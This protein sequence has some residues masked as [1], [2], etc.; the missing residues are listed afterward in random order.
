MKI[1]SITDSLIGMKNNCSFSHHHISR[2]A[3]YCIY[4]FFLPVVIMLIV[5]IGKNIYPFGNNCFLRTDLYHQ[6]LP[7]MC[8]F[9][10]RI[11][12]GESLNFSWNLGLGSNFSAIYAYYLASPVNW[13]CALCPTHD[14]IEF[15]TVLI[16]IK[17]GLCGA[18]CCYYFSKHF[19]VIND[20]MV[21]FSLFY[22]LS[23]FMAAYNWDI[24]WL[25]CIAL[26]PLIILGLEKLVSAGKWKYYCV[27][28][29]LCI[30]TNYYI[31]IMVCLF[32][33]L[34]FIILIL[35][36]PWKQKLRALIQFAF[37]SLLAAC[38]ASVV[39]I[40]GIMALTG[41]KFTGTT[42]P[43]SLEYYFTPDKVLARQCMDVCTELKNDHWPNIYCGVGVL[44][45]FPLYISCPKISL[46][47][48]I[49]VT[50]LL[51]FFILSFSL[52]TLNFIWH[53]LNYPDSLP[54]RQSFLYILVLLTACYEAF[55]HLYE[56]SKKHLLI[57]FVCSAAMVVLFYFRNGN[58]DHFN[59]NRAILSTAIFLGIYALSGMLFY[60]RKG[61]QD[62]VVSF[63]F[64]AALAEVG[65]NTYCTSVSTVSRS[66]YTDKWFRKEAV[67]AGIRKSD[68]DFFRIEEDDRVS[69]NDSVLSDFMSASIFSSTANGDMETFYKNIGLDSSKVY[70]SYDGDTPLTSMLLNVRYMMSESDSNLSNRFRT[71]VTHDNGI[72]IYKAAYDTSIGYMLPSDLETKW[73][74]ESGNSTS[75]QNSFAHALGIKDDL[76]T[77][78]T[79]DTVGNKAT[80][81][82]DQN[83]HL[84]MYVTGATSDICSTVNETL[85]TADGKTLTHTLKK[86]Q[87]SVL[88][89][90]GTLS[91]GDKL[92]LTASE[93]SL[94]SVSLNAYQLNDDAMAETLSIMG[95]QKLVVTDHD[96]DY[97][98]G[99]IDVTEAGRLFLSVPDEEDWTLYVDGVK[100]DYT[101][102][103]DSFVSVDLPAG[104]HEIYLK[105]TP[106]GQKLGILMT[107]I[108]I[109]I[110]SA[111]CRILSHSGRAY[112]RRKAD[113][114]AGLPDGN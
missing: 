92:V 80:V 40:P 63:I 86:C 66:V 113:S 5:I 100:T 14:L 32:L 105:F 54:A 38:L 75:V 52:N 50:A 1:S 28:L 73:D 47:K 59:P 18:S 103:K 7:F 29:A 88:M 15:M 79:I 61:N 16:V 85:T 39:L 49:P 104:T 55:L 110:F 30:L 74:M 87:R 76:F 83:E 69:K 108:G 8:E 3:K 51:A 109:A 53:G 93:G 37:A 10:R 46:K 72:Y 102:F 45:L 23:G 71:L 4:A 78:Y 62:L 84:Y 57:C 95:R 106:V 101:E 98:K 65:I 36:I 56:C 33:I 9:H 2:L 70:Y 91:V 81:I 31:S 20:S 25:D 60:M 11:V 44:F 90:L 6:Y 89:D 22:S 97:L 21:M 48:K 112:A 35:F 13:L 41:T 19:N 58:G 68:N 77:P 17:I 42:F 26:A 67:T 34:Y 99:K 82:A 12:N 64:I 114:S 43:R 24:M 27:T 94:S 111:A 96:D 107:L